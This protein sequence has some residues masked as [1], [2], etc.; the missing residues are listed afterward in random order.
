MFKVEVMDAIPYAGSL[1]T[2]A[3]VNTSFNSDSDEL[4]RRMNLEAAK[5]VKYARSDANGD[6]VISEEEALKFVTLNA[7]IQLGIDDKVGS[8]APGM[9]ADIV[10]WTAPPLSTNAV[11]RH[12]FIDGREYF[13]LEQDARDRAAIAA[14]R[15]RLV[16][17]ILDAPDRDRDTVVND[18]PDSPDDELLASYYRYLED[19]GLD[20]EVARPGDCGCGVLNHRVHYLLEKAGLHLEG[21]GS[22]AGH[23]HAGHGHGHDHAGHDHA[24]HDHHGH[25]H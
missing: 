5:A 6:P 13:S 9:H 25:D 1:Q 23:D 2:E 18:S 10:V 24:G 16:Q 4:S 22:H 20:H 7:A 15:K 3:G 11:P 19:N 21:G 17:E 12:V 8:L 14:E